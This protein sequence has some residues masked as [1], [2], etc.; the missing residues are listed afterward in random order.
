[1]KLVVSFIKERLR[2]M[3]IQ[4]AR[5]LATSNSLQW[6]EVLM[7]VGYLRKKYPNF[8]GYS[9]FVHCIPTT[10]NQPRKVTHDNI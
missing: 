1:M 5:F 2:D 9:A 6:T 10:Y 4:L 3:A 8:G 7:D